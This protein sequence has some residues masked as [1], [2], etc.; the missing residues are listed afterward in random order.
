[1]TGVVPPVAQVEVQDGV[2]AS[3]PTQ[4]VE[5]LGVELDGSDAWP[6]P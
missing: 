6:W 2:A 1:M 3:V 5:L 4:Q